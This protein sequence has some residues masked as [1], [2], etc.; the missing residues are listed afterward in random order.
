MVMM[1]VPRR[2]IVR[3]K[4]I[5]GKEF[6]Y[7]IVSWFGRDKAVAWAAGVHQSRTPEGKIYEVEVEE[8]GEPELGSDGYRLEPDEYTDRMEW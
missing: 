5:D 1:N 2:Y 8:L 6:E 4:S 7:A 3:F